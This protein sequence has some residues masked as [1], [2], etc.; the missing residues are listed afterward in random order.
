[1]SLFTRW[2]LQVIATFLLLPAALQHAQQS[3]I[4]KDAVGGP[5]SVG[6]SESGP[7]SRADSTTVSTMRSTR[8]QSSSPS[9]LE[10]AVDALTN[11]LNQHRKSGILDGEANTLCALGSSYDSFGQEQRAVEQFQL[12]LAIYRETGDRKGEANALSLMGDN[13]GVIYLSQSNKKKAFDYLNQALAAYHDSGDVHAEA[14]ALINIGAAEN[15]VAHDPQKSLSLLQDA[16]TRLS[17]MD[18]LVNQADA[19]EITGMVWIGLHKLDIA[20]ANFPRALILYRQ[21]K[22]PKG[23]A[24]VLKHLSDLHSPQAIASLH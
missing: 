22:D 10:A 21:A 11:V 17:T 6:S 3:G 9:Q 19:F 20:E 24:S 7:L 8:A 1:M 14:L 4:S 16:I 5:S 12:A 15:L 13:L 18:D 2:R 23:E